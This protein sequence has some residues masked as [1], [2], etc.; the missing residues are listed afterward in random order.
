MI[1]YS[2]ESLESR[3]YRD[4]SIT[5]HKKR[6]NEIKARANALS[7]SPVRY[8]SVNRSKLSHDRACAK[9]KERNRENMALYEKLTQIS[10]RKYNRK[11]VKGPKSLNITVRKKDAERII[12]ENLHFVKRLTEKPSFVSAK[13]FEEEYEVL[14]GY[15]HSISKRYLHERLNNLK[16]Y[17]LKPL[18]LPPISQETFKIYEKNEMG[19]G[20]SKGK[21][22]VAASPKGNLS[23][24]KKNAPTESQEIGKDVEEVEENP[25]KVD[26][27][28]EDPVEIPRN[29]AKT[30]E[31]PKKI[32][33]E[34]KADLEIQESPIENSSSLQEIPE[35]PIILLENPDKNAN[36]LESPLDLKE[37]LQLIPSENL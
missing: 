27:I 11:E 1:P 26:K 34:A 8:S 19:K 7:S 25:E 16:G 33:E 30:P 23:G 35:K 6:L 37:D 28:P 4:H 22:A 10:E 31:T 29:N 21:M 24:F 18:L 2:D 32:P 20:E 15:K 5:L 14:K 36:S 9:A 17:D 3:W 12:T 13:K